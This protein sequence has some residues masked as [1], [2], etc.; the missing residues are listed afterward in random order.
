MASGTSPASDGFAEADAA[1]G[2]E[3]EAAAAEAEA[4]TEAAEQAEV[5]AI[6]REIFRDLPEPALQEDDYE[7]VPGSALHSRLVFPWKSI[8]A[9]HRSISSGG[10]F[11]HKP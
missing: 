7:V 8:A 6:L 4:E 5:E 2:P 11:E 3:A 9:L 1:A 10:G